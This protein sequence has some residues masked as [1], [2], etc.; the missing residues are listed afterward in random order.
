MPQAL[1]AL[2][3]HQ[4]HIAQRDIIGLVDFSD[5]SREMRFQLVDVASGR[6]T[7]DWLVAHGRGSDPGNS[8]FVQQFSNRHGSNASSRG[9][10]LTANAYVGSNGRSRRLIGLEPQN[11]LAFDRAIVIHGA[12]YVDRDMARQQGRIGR[13]LGCFTVEMREI[14]AVLEKLPEGCLLYASK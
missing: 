6:V 9:S 1:S 8:G 5:H 14:D 7:A 13:S 4:S 12:D 2:D 11:N 3:T 10:F